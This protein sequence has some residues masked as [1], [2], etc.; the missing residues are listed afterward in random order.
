MP[1][2]Q[3][4]NGKLHAERGG[5]LSLR[6]LEGLKSYAYKP[7]GYTVLDDLHQPVWNC[8]CT[9]PSGTA[10]ACRRRR[11]RLPACTRMSVRSCACLAEW[12]PLASAVAQNAQ[13]FAPV[14]CCQS[15]A[16][17]APPHAPL[18]ASLAHRHHQQLAAAVAGAQP[19]YTDGP[20][21]PAGGVCTGRQVPAGVCGPSTH[22]AARRQVRSRGTGVGCEPAVMGPSC[23]SAAHLPVALHPA[24]HS[25]AQH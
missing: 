5:Y 17:A 1:P 25:Q 18:P 16:I 8:E 15:A 4:T 14:A 13:H 23:G 20:V 22:L 11:R 19:H 2:K 21:G 7:S 10:T 6:A 12:A 9:S 24:A 3:R